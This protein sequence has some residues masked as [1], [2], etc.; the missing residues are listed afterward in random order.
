MSR[1]LPAPTIVWFRDDLRLADNPALRA[2]IDAGRPVIPVFIHETGPDGLR[3]LGAAAKWW[4]YGSLE[5]LDASLR[6]LGSR[7]VLTEGEAL[8]VLKSLVDAT[9]AGEL[10]WN[11]RYHPYAR[12]V[13]ARIKAAIEA[14]GRR[15]RSFNGSLLIEPWEVETGSGTF[16]RVYSPFARAARQKFGF[17]APLPA[18]GGAIPAPAAWPDSLSLPALGLRPTTPDWAG[19]LRE[20]WAQGETA[21]REALSGFID[22]RLVL[23]KAKRDFAAVEATSRLS[24]H[25]RFGEVSP[26][27]VWSA[28][29]HVADTASGATERQSAEKFLSELLWR[30]FSHH[31]LYHLPP[32][33]QA[34]VQ[35]KFDAFPWHQSDDRLA[36]WEKGMTGYPIVDAGM[37]QLWQ[38]GWMHN[39][40]R[41][42]VASFLTKDLL[43]DWRDGEAWFWNTLVDADPA[44]NPA[45]WQWV[46]G[47]GADAAPYFRVF[48]PVLQGRKFDPEGAYVRA[49]VPELAKL[50]AKYVHEPWTAPGEVLE[51]AGVILGQT[52]PERIVDHAAARKRALEAY[53]QIKDQAA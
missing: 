11:R 17:V 13:D 1:T 6:K 35:D 18:P 43:V 48:N 32:L 19:G 16:Y 34:N 51:D 9:G 53:Q 22:E 38:T 33:E 14:D 29:S 39:R 24:P 5:A 23:Y 52:Y 31:I 30:E 28:L 21:A 8:G 4:L 12:E 3:P 15:A 27:T 20:T 25:L 47:S 44:N 50:P 45:S 42:V 40:V 26:R 37:R 36:A 49:F 10:V 46:S 7:L 41:M 2:A